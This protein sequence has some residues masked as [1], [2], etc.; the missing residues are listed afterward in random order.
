MPPPRRLTDSDYVYLLLQEILLNQILQ[1]FVIVHYLT[2]L[3]SRKR[4][5]NTQAAPYR[6]IPRIPDQVKHMSRIVGLTDVDCVVNLRMDRNAFGRLCQL[7]RDLGGLVDGRYVSIQEQVSMFLSV[8]AHHKK[9]RVVRFDFW[10]SG[11]TCSR[12]IH[13]VLRAIL[14]LHVI[15]LVKPEL[16]PDDCTDSRWKWFK[17]C[18]GALDGTYINVEGF[19]TPYKGVR[20]HLKEWGPTNARPQNKEE[21]FNLKYS[22]ARNAIERAFGIMKMRWGILRG[23]TYYPIKIQNRLMMCCFLLN[24]FIRSQMNIDPIEQHFDMLVNE[25]AL[26]ENGDEFVDTVESSPEW[27]AARDHIADGM[28]NDYINAT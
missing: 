9:N 25:G 13:L 17:G 24:N 6:M 22:K 16:V 8:L 14:R 20:Y 18:L 19:L 5:R 12:Y 23:T 4:K 11:Q 2:K 28:W 27:N 7:L 10:R 26:G 21:L 1:L 3:N 15:L